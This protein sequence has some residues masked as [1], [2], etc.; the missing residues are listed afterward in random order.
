MGQAEYKDSNTDFLPE[1]S[2]TID[3]LAK[4]KVNG[5][6]DLDLGV[7]NLLDSTYYKYQN[8]RGIRSTQADLKKFAEPGRSL[9]AGFKF[10]F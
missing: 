3:L 2:M 5:S 10:R 8:V 1:T 4:Y 6:L 7:T 9:N